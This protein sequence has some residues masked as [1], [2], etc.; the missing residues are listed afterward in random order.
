MV[1]QLSVVVV[2]RSGPTSHT[3]PNPNTFSLAMISDIQMESTSPSD[4]QRR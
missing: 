3:C 2:L 4:R 1:R